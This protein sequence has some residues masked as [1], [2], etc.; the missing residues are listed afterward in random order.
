MPAY[1][2]CLATLTIFPILFLRKSLGRMKGA[3]HWVEIELAEQSTQNAQLKS[4]S[5][6]VI[7]PQRK[8]SQMQMYG[9]EKQRVNYEKS[10]IHR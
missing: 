3:R 9:I 5:A 10:N 6:H 2:S 4:K 8:G 7:A 1:V